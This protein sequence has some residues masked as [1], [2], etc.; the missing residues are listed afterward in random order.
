MRLDDALNWLKEQGYFGEP[1]L[2]PWQASDNIDFDYIDLSQINEPLAV[3]YDEILG[4][5]EEVGRAFV[6]GVLDDSRLKNL[7]DKARDYRMLKKLST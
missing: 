7:H 5:C 2:R 4:L 3:L 6:V 1:N